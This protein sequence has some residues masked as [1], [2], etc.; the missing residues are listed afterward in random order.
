M[1]AQDPVHSA[2]TLLLSLLF[3]GV[4]EPPGDF[5][6]DNNAKLGT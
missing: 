2:G 6:L 5:K 3:L 1:Y 4:A